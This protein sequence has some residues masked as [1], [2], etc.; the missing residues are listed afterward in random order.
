MT[1]AVSPGK[2]CWSETGPEWPGGGRGASSAMVAV[3]PMGALGGRA[4]FGLKACPPEG[5]AGRPE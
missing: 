1:V 2:L 4:P 5:E 3:A